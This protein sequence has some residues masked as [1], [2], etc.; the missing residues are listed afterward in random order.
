MPKRLSRSKSE[1]S[2]GGTCTDYAPITPKLINLL[3]PPPTRMKV[4]VRL[5]WRHMAFKGV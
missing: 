1:F 5:A 2:M 4:I 3:K